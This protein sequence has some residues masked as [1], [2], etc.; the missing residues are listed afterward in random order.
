MQATVAA[1]LSNRIHH[2]PTVSVIPRLAR[3]RA[4]TADAHPQIGDGSICDQDRSP[5]ITAKRLVTLFRVF[6]LNVATSAGVGHR[7]GSG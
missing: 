3:E 4:T 5:F 6:R 7:S 2:S 1:R